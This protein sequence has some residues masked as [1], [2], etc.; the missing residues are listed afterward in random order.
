MKTHKLFKQIKLKRQQGKKGGSQKIK[1]IT[2][3]P[4]KGRK[5]TKRI[6]LRDHPITVDYLTNAVRTNYVK[7][8]CE[9]SGLCLLLHL[10]MQSRNI[11]KLFNNFLDFEYA[12]GRKLIGDPSD[13]GFVNEIIFQRNNYEAYAILKSSQREDSD[14]LWYEYLIGVHINR[15]Y[16]HKFLCFVETY[17]A[18]HYRT[19]GDGSFTTNKSDMALNRNMKKPLSKML[20]LIPFSEKPNAI[21]DS[22]SEPERL[23]ILIQ[24][25]HNSI[26]LEDMLNS[27][28]CKNFLKYDLMGCLYQ[29][30][31]SLSH[32]S[33]SFTHNDLHLKNILL[34]PLPVSNTYILF[35]FHCEN[36]AEIIIKSKYI[37]KIIDYGKAYIENL[38]ENIYE[39]ALGK[40]SINK[41]EYDASRK[42]YKKIHHIKQADLRPF[43]MLPRVLSMHGNLY[44]E[45]VTLIHTCKDVIGAENGI[46]QLLSLDTEAQRQ[47]EDFY[48]SYL[49]LGVIDISG[50]TDFNFQMTINKEQYSNRRTKKKSHKN[51]INKN[52]YSPTEEDKDPGDYYDLRFLKRHIDDT[53]TTDLY[54]IT[55]KYLGLGDFI[56][57]VDEN[58]DARGRR[59]FLGSYVVHYLTNFYERRKY[60]DY[61]SEAITNERHEELE[62]VATKVFDLCYKSKNVIEL[63]KRGF[64]IE[65]LNKTEE[66]ARPIT[67]TEESYLIKYYETKMKEE[68]N[69]E[70][71]E[72]DPDVK[73]DLD[74]KNGFSN[75]VI[76]DQ[77]TVSDKSNIRSSTSSNKSHRSS[78]SNKSHKSSASN[79]SH[80]SSASNRSHRTSESNRSRRSTESNRGHRSSE[81]NRSRRSTES[82][83]SHKS[84]ESNDNNRG[85]WSV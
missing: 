5:T 60:K 17:S 39:N 85:F 25:I 7:Q 52:Y 71:I 31:F 32:L 82:K 48:R 70:S 6:T 30:Y 22:C 76:R 77:F 38:T 84:N 75:T 37:V 54:D 11:K 8:K 33:R 51:E 46:R 50:K 13:N 79:K 40:C 74:A 15:N 81:S 45:L 56:R 55:G 41:R 57:L 43:K 29:I 83:R 27:T 19:D 58:T 20:S 14:N 72:N 78:A 63:A 59:V 68:D 66:L 28:E 16:Y 1:F 9:D 44:P 65:F 53:W 18:Y 67:K 61:S 49:E 26:D 42:G 69:Y 35:R 4:K 3:A 73:N 10:G 36:G 34:C 47:N 23:A 64:I 12:I 62:R 2:S 80:K 24:Y 21:A